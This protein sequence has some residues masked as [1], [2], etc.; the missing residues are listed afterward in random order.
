MQGTELVGRGTAWCCTCASQ[1]R[2]DMGLGPVEQLERDRQK[3]PRPDDYLRLALAGVMAVRRT[4]VVCCGPSSSKNA[5][6]LNFTTTIT[7]PIPIQRH[8]FYLYCAHHGVNTP[9]AHY[10]A[11]VRAAKSLP[12][13]LPMPTHVCC[14]ASNAI[15]T[16]LSPWAPARDTHAPAVRCSSTRRAEEE[17]GRHDEAGAGDARGLRPVQQAQEHAGE[18]LL[19]GC[20]CQ[21]ERR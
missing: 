20:P 4:A 8:C 13:P 7:R 15:A 9:G 17:A 21:G 6:A 14:T 11:A 10:A 1:T 16:S 18:A 3:L 19:E 12:S 5:P 2:R